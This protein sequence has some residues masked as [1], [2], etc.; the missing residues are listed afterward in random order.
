MRRRPVLSQ[1]HA[2]PE[3]LNFVLATLL[4]VVQAATAQQ[5]IR[6]WVQ[7]RAEVRLMWPIKLIFVR[8]IREDIESHLVSREFI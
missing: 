7:K 3:R 8:N 4:G 1:G 6:R 2:R 5:C